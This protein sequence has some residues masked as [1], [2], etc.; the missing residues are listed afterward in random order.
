[1]FSRGS[2]MLWQK[3]L[4]IFFVNFG[5]ITKLDNQLSVK[6]NKIKILGKFCSEKKF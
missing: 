5:D 3:Y 2:P 1:M 4:Y 6:K